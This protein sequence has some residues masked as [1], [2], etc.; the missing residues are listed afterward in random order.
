ML[1]REEETTYLGKALV[2]ISQ[3]RN[4]PAAPDAAI[5]QQRCLRRLH[6]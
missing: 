3:R 4:E 5:D 6:Q 1:V 2:A